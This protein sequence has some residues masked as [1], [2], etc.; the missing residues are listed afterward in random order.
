MNR[1]RFSPIFL[2]F[3]FILFAC[4]GPKEEAKRHLTLGKAMIDSSKYR[5][6]LGEF[7]L[8]FQ[9]DTTLYEA[10]FMTAKVKQQVKDYDGSIVD[11]EKLITKGYKLDTVYY[12]LG[13]NYFEKGFSDKKGGMSLTSQTKHY[14]KS[15]E[16]LEKAVSVNAGYLSAYDL[17]MQAEYNSEKYSEVMSTANTLLKLDS[18]QYA[19]LVLRADTKWQLGDTLSVLTDLTKVI[20]SDR[21]DTASVAMARQRRGLIYYDQKLFARALDDYTQAIRLWPSAL[22]YWDRGLVYLDMKDKKSACA[23]FRKA[24]DLGYPDAYNY[25]KKYCK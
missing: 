19:A 12:L 17:K 15:I 11:L 1:R 23:D 5:E 22:Y 16:Y 18:T 7:Q 14:P 13:S 6:A 9:K 21:A 25:I 8:A 20:E 24:A 4:S 2:G 3:I 10:L